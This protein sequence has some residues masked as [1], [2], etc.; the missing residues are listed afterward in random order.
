MLSTFL[1]ELLNEGRVTV[2]GEIN[3]FDSRDT[4][5][6]LAAIRNYYDTDVLEMPGVAPDFDGEAALWAA[7]YLYTCIQLTVLRDLDEE[8]V[9]KHLDDF[10]GEITPAAVYSADLLL[11]YLPA[12]FDLARGLAP[13][14]ILVE[15]MKHTSFQWPFSSVGIRLGKEPDLSAVLAHPSLKCAYIDRIIKQKDNDRL[16][17]LGIAQLVKEAL[18]NHAPV[19][20]PELELYVQKE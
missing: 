16:K 15:L 18:G 10:Q 1:Q 6:A 14:D 11:R 17:H 4:E 20:W 19:L 12:V 8:E 3:A 9:K 2:A 7:K 13:G 5:Q